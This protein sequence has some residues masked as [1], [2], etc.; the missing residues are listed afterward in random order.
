VTTTVLIGL[1]GT[2]SAATN[3]CSRGSSTSVRRV[4][5]LELHPTTALSSPLEIS[6]LSLLSLA[7]QNVSPFGSF[8]EVGYIV[9]QCRDDLLWVLHALVGDSLK[10]RGR[11]GSLGWMS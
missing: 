11:L 10:E 2:C 4:E 1:L 3:S 5:R 9:L 7:A 8:V 6:L